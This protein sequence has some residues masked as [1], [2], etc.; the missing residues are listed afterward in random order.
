MPP[1]DGSGA[2]LAGRSGTVVVRRLA[3]LVFTLV[4]IGRGGPK[5]TRPG[6]WVSLW[7]RGD[8]LGRRPSS[9]ELF[10]HEAPTPRLA[11]FD[12]AHHRVGRLAEVRRGVPLR[13]RVAAAHM[14][15]V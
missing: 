12:R 3:I 6:R 5:L 8:R 15:A 9:A 4:F 13:R 10:V 1:V 7:A 2:S 14:A 11:R